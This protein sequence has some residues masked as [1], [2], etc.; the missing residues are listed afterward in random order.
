[1]AQKTCIHKDIPNS[2]WVC[3]CNNTYCDEL[4]P[5]SRPTAPGVV[6]VYESNK[7]GDRFKRNELNVNTKV[8]YNG[9]KRQTITIDETLHYQKIYGF[10]GAFTDTTGM[11]L[12]SINYS[13]AINIIDGYFSGNGIEYSFGRVPISGTDY[14][15]RYC[16]ELPPIS[17]PT[18]PGVVLVYESN[19]SGDRF[20]R[21]ELNVNT[22]VSYN[23]TKRQT[24]TIDE[25]LHYQK[26]YGFGGAFTDTTGMLLNSINYSL[27]I[28][29]ID[30]YFSGNGIEYSFGRVP[31]SGTDYSVR[32]YTYDDFANDTDLTRFSLQYEDYVWKIPYIKLAQKASPHR[33]KLIATSWSPPSWMKTTERIKVF[34]PLKGQPGGQY[35][36][37]LANYL[38][39]FLEAYRENGVTLWG[40]TV[41]N[42]PVQDHGI[43]GLNMS[44]EQERD[45]I[46]LHLGPTLQRAGYGRDKLKLLMF[47]DTS[48]HLREYVDTILVDRESAKY[49]SGIAMHWYYNQMMGPFPDLLLDYIYQNYPE[50]FVINT[51]A[52]SLTGAMNGNWIYAENYAFDIIRDMNH[53]VRGWLEWNMALDMRGGPTW[54]PKHGCG[55]PVYVD[56]G[57]GEAYKQPTYYAL[58]HFAKFI[59]P[60]SVRISHTLSDRSVKGLS[61]LTAKRVD[62]GV[63]VTAL[64]S[65]DE[66]I[67][68]HMNDTT[69]GQHFQHIITAHSIQSYIWW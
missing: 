30:G 44:A 2:D 35:Y 42:E 25:T 32:P 63:V 65:A 56:V 37:I 6:L 4:P 59:S 41:Q 61:V 66:D 57:A 69:S 18:A 21:S 29:I 20:K 33:I 15:V 68:L 23:G 34:A 8:S 31:I 17:R 52:C 16:D 38:V 55:G 22:K 13:L 62:N 46:K 48:P 40:L 36:Q 67:V 58:A 5:I 60:D 45:F 28:N 26:I 49:I 3:V 9:T 47:D 64:N 14:S 50:F 24:I 7:S 12:N 54:M 39:K 10:G 19:K 11:L 53:W 43:N 1:S 51:E 27:A